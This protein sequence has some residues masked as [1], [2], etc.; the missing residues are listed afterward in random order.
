M[1]WKVKEK[2]QK[3]RER[4]NAILGETI[5]FSYELWLEAY[6]FISPLLLYKYR[7]VKN[8]Q[9]HKCIPEK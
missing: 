6:S 2:Q 8:C 3:V 1:T 9:E 4:E 5:P 7:S